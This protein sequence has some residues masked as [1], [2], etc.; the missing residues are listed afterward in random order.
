MCVRKFNNYKPCHG[1]VLSESEGNNRTN[2]NLSFAARY[3]V[4]E[5][6]CI[7]PFLLW[8]NGSHFTPT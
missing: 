7:M 5:Q 4:I 6:F 3:N 1:K 8:R 2:P